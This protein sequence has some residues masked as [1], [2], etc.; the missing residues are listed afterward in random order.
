[1]LLCAIV[2]LTVK[3]QELHICPSYVSHGLSLCPNKW[4]RSG[5][6]LIAPTGMNQALASSWEL[7]APVAQGAPEVQL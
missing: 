2:P 1:M 7:N 3:Q 5:E 6:G 4:H